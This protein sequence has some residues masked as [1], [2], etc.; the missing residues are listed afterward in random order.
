MRS[1]LPTASCFLN[2]FASTSDFKYKL[3]SQ[4]LGLLHSAYSSS[5]KANKVSSL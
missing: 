3:W 1:L 4:A 5:K 2:Q